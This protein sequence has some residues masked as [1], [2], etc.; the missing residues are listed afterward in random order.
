MQSDEVNEVMFG[1][2]ACLINR[3]R[4]RMREER[5]IR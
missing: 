2:D 5:K 4:V 3:H 1:K